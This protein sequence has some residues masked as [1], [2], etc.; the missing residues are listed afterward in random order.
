V[1][2]KKE[3]DIYIKKGN[4]NNGH[5]MMLTIAKERGEGNS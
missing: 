1:T 2:S 3:T 5:K 4:N